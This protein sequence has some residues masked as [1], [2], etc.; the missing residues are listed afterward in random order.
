MPDHL[1]DPGEQH[2]AAMAHLAFDRASAGGFVILELAAELGHLACAQ[3]IDR[4]MIAALAIAGDFSLAQQLRHGRSS[5]TLIVRCNARRQKFRRRVSP[6]FGPVKKRWS[7]A[8]SPAPRHPMV[9]LPTLE[10]PRGR[11]IPGWRLK[12]VH[13]ADVIAMQQLRCANSPRPARA[14]R[15]VVIL[16][17]NIP[18]C[19][20]SFCKTAATKSGRRNGENDNGLWDR[21]CTARCISG[22]GR[23]DH[24][25]AEP[26]HH[27]AAARHRLGGDRRH[28]HRR[29]PEKDHPGRRRSVRQRR[30]HHRVRRL[31]RA[32]A[33]SNRDRRERDP[34][35]GGA[36]RRPAAGHRDDHHAGD[37][38]SCSPPC[39]ASAP[40][41]RSASS[42]CRS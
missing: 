41:S 26:D 3:R 30:D 39:T 18:L 16:A 27:A 4:K 2:V 20:T 24:P 1:V 40:R 11:S 35:R 10:Y 34:V 13:P 38:R 25:R 9:K 14:R 5:K 31:V 15:R 32:G 29:H 17:R 23:I 36:R 8:A 12:G 21:R 28:R 22:G 42:R 6:A 37:R 33:D 19:Q 7:M